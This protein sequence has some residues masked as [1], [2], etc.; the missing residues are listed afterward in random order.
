MS[1]YE[2]FFNCEEIKNDELTRTGTVKKET[3]MSLSEAL[4]EL[5]KQFDSATP[6]EQDR[7][8][9]DMI[10]MSNEFKKMREQGRDELSNKQDNPE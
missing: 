9:K 10:K 2:D 7:M 5:I 3:F 6:D 4:K 1:L 8:T